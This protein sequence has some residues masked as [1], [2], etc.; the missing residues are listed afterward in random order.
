MPS[1]HLLSARS[2]MSKGRLIQL[3]TY[4]LY[5]A[6]LF[7]PRVL[8]YATTHLF[9]NWQKYVIFTVYALQA[10]VLMVLI[11]VAA[12]QR[13]KTHEEYPRASR[14]VREFQTLWVTLWVIWFIFYVVLAAQEFLAAKENVV[15]VSPYWDL[16]ANLFNNLQTVFILLC[17]VC[18]SVP[19][20]SNDQGKNYV[21][22]GGILGVLLAV[23]FVVTIVNWLFILIVQPKSDDLGVTIFR[24]L[25][26]ITLG[27]ALALLVGQLGNIHI[28]ASRVYISALYLY[29]VIQLS[30]AIFG[31]SKYVQEI[32]TTMSL[33]LK[34]M[35][36]VQLHSLI[37]SGRL[38][39][40]ME[41]ARLLDESVPKDW[42][43]FQTQI[44]QLSSSSSKAA[45]ASTGGQT[46]S[47]PT[48]G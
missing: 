31:G 42:N 12:L 44:T 32:F 9:P 7:V 11:A 38:L 15:A 3:L 19:T 5:V 41:K 34:L 43:M 14:A 21:R 28:H 17:Y 6:V 8:N 25:S 36:F 29:A 13:P 39:F 48:T 45:A 35:L 33:P 46:Q 1:S 20:Q 4:L 23:I 47:S 18:L 22:V 30:Y 37:R 24:L 10:S 40:Y 16:G 2:D 27:T 26:G